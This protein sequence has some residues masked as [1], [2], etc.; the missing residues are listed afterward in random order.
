MAGF[1]DHSVLIGSYFEKKAFQ[2]FVKAFIF[3][4]S[5]VRGSER[6]R[7]QGRVCPRGDT[8]DDLEGRSVL[9][10]VSCGSSK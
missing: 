7:G 8:L 9:E 10:E 5:D 3:K 2:I 1:D 4:T 6:E